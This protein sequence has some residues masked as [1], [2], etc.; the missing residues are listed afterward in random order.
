M[1]RDMCHCTRE[2]QSTTVHER[3]L[4]SFQMCSA[5]EIV[6]LLNDA[7]RLAKL[8]KDEAR[9]TLSDSIFTL[10]AHHFLSQPIS[11]D[12]LAVQRN[13]YGRCRSSPLD[14]AE[15]DLLVL[16]V[17][18]CLRS[19][20]QHLQ[21][22]FLQYLHNINRLLPTHVQDLAYLCALMLVSSNNRNIIACILCAHLEMQSTT[23]TRFDVMINGLY[24]TEDE[25]EDNPWLD[26]LT[27]KLIEKDV[28]WLRKFYLEKKFSKDLLNA[29]D[30][31]DKE[32]ITR[33]ELFQHD[34]HSSV[35]E[36]TPGE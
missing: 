2:R 5:D 7:P 17:K 35:T 1:T 11:E 23:E 9:S 28:A 10:I 32:N 4:S 34:S 33:I 19:N 15:L 25:D 22:P 16:N 36:R 27:S 24:E 31:H 12:G 20:D 18:E 3:R 29:I 14:Q 30:R 6:P 13:L 8:L 26:Q 21:R